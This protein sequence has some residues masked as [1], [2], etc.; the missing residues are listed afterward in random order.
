MGLLGM[1]CFA[2]GF[3]SDPTPLCIPGIILSL[4]VS[5]ILFYL[6]ETLPYSYVMFGA[7]IVGTFIVWTLI[8][9][10]VRYLVGLISRRFK[11]QP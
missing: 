8:G 9:F 3:G 11:K 2:E 10:I 6:A 4:P 1:Y 7:D 5:I